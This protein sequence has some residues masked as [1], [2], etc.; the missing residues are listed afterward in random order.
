MVCIL[1]ASPKLYL[2]NKNKKSLFK[3]QRK[4]NKVDLI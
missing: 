4:D 1:S 3:T 2:K